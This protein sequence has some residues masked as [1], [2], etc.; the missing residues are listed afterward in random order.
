[1][2]QAKFKQHPIEYF[3]GEH[4]AQAVAQLRAY[5]RKTGFYSTNLRGHRAE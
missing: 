3:T 2:P 4:R 1:M 5:R